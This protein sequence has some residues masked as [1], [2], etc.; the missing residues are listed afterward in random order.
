MLA[1][2]AIVVVLLALLG[3]G[4]WA[5]VGPFSSPTIAPS[6]DGRIAFIRTNTQGTSRSLYVVN[7]D[8]S[9][10]QQIAPDL[11]VDSIGW[12]PSGRYIVAQ[13]RFATIDGIVRIAVGDDNKAGEVLKLTPDITTDSVNPT[14]SP[15]GSLI[16]FQTKRDG[17]DYQVFVMNTDG[18][19]KR[20][21]SDGKGYAGQ[22]AFSPDSKSLVY[23]QGDNNLS[24]MQ[25]YVAPIA[26]GAPKAIAAP[27]SSAAQPSWSADGKTVVFLKVVGDRADTIMAVPSQG[28]D[29]RTLSDT[30]A[31]QSVHISPDGS[32]VLY[33][34]I[35]QQANAGTQL[36]TVPLAGGTPKQ[37][38]T[39]GENYYPSWSPDGKQITYAGRTSE[40]SAHKIVISNAD[41]TNVQTISSGDGDDYLPL[42]APP[43]ATASATPTTS[44]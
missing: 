31:I 23:V 18:S 12:A 2:G 39:G 32:T 5:G 33:H 20:R 21:I 42:W 29:V 13:A 41:G 3:L 24:P 10:Q 7:P 28:G 4:A 26:G 37:L 43:V 14:W 25:V 8:G 17:G 44:K 40:S 22:P 16:A 15:D 36:F 27:G 34:Q 1:G 11:Y 9:N 38:T 6:P 19:N 35:I 30:G